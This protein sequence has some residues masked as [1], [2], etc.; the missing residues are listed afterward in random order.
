MSRQKPVGPQFVGIPQFFGLL[1]RTVLHPG[2]RIVGQ[3]SWLSRSGQL[4]E[5]G[6]E[7]ELKTLSNAKHHG[8]AA[9]LMVLRNGLV[10]L[11]GEG[12]QQKRRPLGATPLLRSRLADGLQFAEFL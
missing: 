11:A 2:N 8:A 12:I 7:A 9:D 3:L 6:V 1:A 10:A 4:G 5:G